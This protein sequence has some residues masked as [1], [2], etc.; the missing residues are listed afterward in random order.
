MRGIATGEKWERDADRTGRGI[1]YFFTSG[2][3]KARGEGEGEGGVVA[4][5]I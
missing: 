2:N 3:I 1:K 5:P 4:T